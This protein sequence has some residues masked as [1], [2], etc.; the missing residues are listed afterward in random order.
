M[1]GAFN[2]CQI[3]LMFFSYFY[4]NSPGITMS[5][6]PNMAK[7]DADNPF[8]RRS[9]GKITANEQD[10]KLHAVHVFSLKISIH[11]FN[12]SRGNYKTPILSCSHN[13]H[14]RFGLVTE[15]YKIVVIRV[16]LHIGHYG[17]YI[18]DLHVQCN[19][20]LFKSANWHT[21]S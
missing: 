1:S 5:P 21:T 3:L 6:R 20:L 12:I 8:S 19:P 4:I 11:F 2:L 17:N 15:K 13:L 16:Y 7:F 9:I 10:N 18:S 14:T